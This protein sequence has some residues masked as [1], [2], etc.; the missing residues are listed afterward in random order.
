MT[1]W[2]ERYL[3]AWDSMDVDAVLEWMTDDV[4][5]EDTTA[6]YSATGRDEMR[7]FVKASF[8]NVPDARFEFL[9]GHDDGE[10]YAI[11]WIMQPMGVPGVSVGRLRDGKVCCNRDYWNGALFDVPN[12]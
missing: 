3:S 12:T 9:R 4:Y 6:R 5:F 7:R 10:S 8:R 1:T 11:E 2:Y